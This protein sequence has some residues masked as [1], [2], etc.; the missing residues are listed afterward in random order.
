L[1]SNPRPKITLTRINRATPDTRFYIDFDWWD[2][3]NLDLKTYLL[4]RL[5]ASDAA[6]LDSGFEKVDLID[7]QTGEV[8]QV[9][10]FQYMVQTYF[11]QLPAD[12]LTNASLVDAAFCV[13]L[14][15]ANQPMTAREIAERIKRPSDVV[16]RTL[17]GPKIYQ[18]IRPIFDE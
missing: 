3:S 1:S 18:G 16:V 9:D 4:A 5:S 13:L 6:T 15:N 2:E 12:F 8:H 17:G 11:H 14:A 10:G 7:P